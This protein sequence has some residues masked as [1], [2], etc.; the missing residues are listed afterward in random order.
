MEGGRKYGLDV[1]GGGIVLHFPF[2]TLL[3]LSCVC[4]GGMKWSPTLLPLPSF[5]PF[6]PYM[7]PFVRLCAVGSPMGRKKRREKEKKNHGKPPTERGEF[8]AIFL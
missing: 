1:G 5:L 8:L 4:I 7:L 6:P 2:S 3:S